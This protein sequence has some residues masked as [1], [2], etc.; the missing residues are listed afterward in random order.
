VDFLAA[1]KVNLTISHDA[2]GFSRRDKDNLLDNPKEKEIW[3]YAKEKYEREG[4]QF[5]FN[6]VITNENSN[7][8]KIADYFKEHFAEDASFGFEGAVIPSTPDDILRNGEEL[9]QSLLDGLLDAERS[10]LLGAMLKRCND[11]FEA[12]K[13]GT[14]I[15]SVLAKCDVANKNSLVVDLQGR[16]IACHNESPMTHTIGHL[17]EYGKVN[18]EFF[19]PLYTREDCLKCP[20]VQS[21]HGSCP[22]ADKAQH[23]FACANERIFHFAIFYAVWLFTFQRHILSITPIEERE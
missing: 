10:P 15:N 12:F 13:D 14:P 17:K 22:L 19:H 16:I 8:I 23:L 18:T 4:L 1:H 20:V 6:V 2:Q 11:L 7:F 9:I 21:C 5:G 3:L